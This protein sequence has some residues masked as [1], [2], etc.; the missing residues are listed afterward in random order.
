VSATSAT[1]RCRSRRVIGKADPRF[2]KL[3]EDI[4]KFSGVDEI[5]NDIVNWD[6]TN[7][8]RYPRASLG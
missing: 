7:D 2:L 5:L 3:A 6:S 1:Y 8:L 4:L